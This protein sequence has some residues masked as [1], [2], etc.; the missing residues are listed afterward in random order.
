MPVVV[1]VD[2]KYSSG[3]I[4][5]GLPVSL[6]AQCGLIPGS[7]LSWL[8]GIVNKDS[9]SLNSKSKSNHGHGI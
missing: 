9:L 3:F 2:E 6:S 8:V 1:S 4:L 5:L 7:P